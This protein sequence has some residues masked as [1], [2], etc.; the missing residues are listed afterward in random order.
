LVH[1]AVYQEENALPGKIPEN[2]KDRKK[3]TAGIW[4]RQEYDYDRKRKDRFKAGFS[5]GKHLSFIS[6]Q[7]GTYCLLSAALVDPLLLL[8][9]T[10]LWCVLTP[11]EIANEYTRNQGQIFKLGIFCNRMH[12]G[13]RIVLK[14]V[15]GY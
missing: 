9:T 11:S 3:V 12:E 10:K 14:T 2:D 1:T 4:L 8:P 6:Q 5:T 15:T 13:Y 7:G